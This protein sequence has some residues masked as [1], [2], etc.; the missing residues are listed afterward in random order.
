MS[1]GIYGHNHGCR[2]E[3]QIV[4]PCHQADTDINVEYGEPHTYVGAPDMNSNVHS[5]TTSP[6]QYRRRRHCQIPGQQLAST[7]SLC[8]IH[9][10]HPLRTRGEHDPH[11][12]PTPN[13]AERLVPVVCIMQSIPLFPSEH[14]GKI[15]KTKPFPFSTL[16][17][18]SILL[19][20]QCKKFRK[21]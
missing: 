4:R 19:Y 5:A 20:R 3:L 14:R 1:Q 8:R 9:R 17:Y 12:L 16:L 7:Q 15:H 21:G 6:H 10:V 2:P 18:V 13:V 11:P